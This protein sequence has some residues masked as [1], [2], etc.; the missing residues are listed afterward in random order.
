[1][2][3]T[4]FGYYYNQLGFNSGDLKVYYDF[5]SLNS[6]NGSIYSGVLS[7]IGNFYQKT[8]SGYFTGQSVLIQ[9]SDSLASPNWTMM[10]IYEKS[11]SGNQVLFS[12][13]HENPPYSGVLTLTGFRQTDLDY[14]GTPG[15]I[16]PP[17]SP[18]DVNY[19]YIYNTGNQYWETTGN[20]NWINGGP[21]GWSLWI[22]SMVGDPDA[23]PQFWVNYHSQ[24]TGQWLRVNDGEDVAGAGFLSGFHSSPTKEGFVI[25]VNDLN[26]PYLETWGTGEQPIVKTFPGSSYSKNLLMATCAN[27]VFSMGVY[28]FVNFRTNTKTISLL[29]TGLIASTGWYLGKAVNP[30][31]YFSG[32][33][34]TGYIDEFVF[35]S[36][37][38]LPQSLAIL[39]S[40]FF[41][42]RSLVYDI[43]AKKF[44]YI[45]S[46]L[47]GKVTNVTVNPLK[48][49][50]NSVEIKYLNMKSGTA[51]AY[52]S[53]DITGRISKVTGDITGFT[54]SGSGYALTTPQITTGVTGYITTGGLLRF[55]LIKTIIV[56]GFGET[57]AN[58]EYNFIFDGGGYRR[59]GRKD[60]PE[61]KLDYDNAVGEWSIYKTE[62]TI[63]YKSNSLFSGWYI[64]D[65]APGIGTV[66][67][68]GMT[69]DFK[70][71]ISGFGVTGTISSGVGNTTDEFQNI[72]NVSGR[73]NLTGITG[74]SGYVSI[75]TS[76]LSGAISGD[77]IT[78]IGINY[79]SIPFY[80]TISYSLTGVSGSGYFV[81]NST[82]VNNSDN[83][84][85]TYHQIKYQNVLIQ[86]TPFFIYKS[87]T[88]LVDIVGSTGIINTSFMNSFITQSSNFGSAITDYATGLI[89]DN[90]GDFFDK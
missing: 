66:S 23:Y 21:G 40:G 10:M 46:N 12:N 5:K 55:D 36:K 82:Y 59:W 26:K 79:T 14:N 61:I 6:T 11:G 50:V 18:S 73:L 3:S 30:P 57:A 8:G 85:K 39:A 32:I 51:T 88:Q 33:P 68:L 7:S 56:S 89:F 42:E 48:R 45:Y 60:F 54:M 15:P 80:E 64:Y 28:D 47:T 37:C 27:N 19:N 70:M 25:G 62:D 63:G 52:V 90:S 44:D 69:L 38:L 16:G 67:V 9:N 78:G 43:V 24:P 84:I 74:L 76:P 86:P 17:G 20:A 34:F 41:A 35:I 2:A 13:Y 71:P 72:Y 4:G 81:F 31:P 83:Y 1:M 53:G 87:G 22:N 49:L 29:T 58:N 77:L 75:F 65:A